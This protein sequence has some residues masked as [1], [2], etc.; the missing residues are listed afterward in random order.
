[1]RVR[2][3]RRSVVIPLTSSALFRGRRSHS[4]SCLKLSHRR[5]RSCILLF[6]FALLPP[7][8]LLIHIQLTYGS[9]APAGF[10]FVPAG[11]PEITEWCKEQCRQRNLDVHIV[12]V[13]IAGE[14][15]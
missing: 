13:G 6:V 4:K 7:R 1:M 15:A 8:V 5:R 3:T 12:S 2:D 9:D 10:G 14:F 11:H